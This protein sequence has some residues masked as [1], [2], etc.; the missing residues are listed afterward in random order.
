MQHGL[1]AMHPLL[2][3]SCYTGVLMT[4]YHML[5]YRGTGAWTAERGPEDEVDLEM[6]GA[7]MRRGGEEPWRD[8]AGRQVD[9]AVGIGVERD[10]ADVGVRRARLV[11]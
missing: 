7:V 2:Y 4:V 5:L 10:V 6:R 3:S 1:Y 11:C 8:G 9:V